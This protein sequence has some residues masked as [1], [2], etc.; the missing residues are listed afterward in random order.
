M[1]LYS[2]ETATTKSIHINSPNTKPTAI[3]VKV[4]PP[5]QFHGV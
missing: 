1:E 4:T 2:L 5:H 3:A